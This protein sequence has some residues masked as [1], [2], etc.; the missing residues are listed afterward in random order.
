MSPRY[1]YAQLPFQVQLG[2]PK[3]SNTGSKSTGSRGGTRLGTWRFGV[4]VLSSDDEGSIDWVHPGR[5]PHGGH[6]VR[7]RQSLAATFTV[8]L[9][10]R[11]AKY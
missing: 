9:D 1:L 2:L 11:I 10:E 7:A 6:P 3:E 8:S 5:V 4:H